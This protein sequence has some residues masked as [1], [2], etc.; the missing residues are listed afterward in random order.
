MA[1]PRIPKKARV[2]LGLLFAVFLLINSI[3][4]V[5]EAAAGLTGEG[6]FRFLSADVS[7]AARLLLFVIGIGT[8]WLLARM[9]YK[10]LI[11]GKITV[12]DSVNTAYIL[13]FYLLLTF[14]TFSFLGAIGWFWLPLLF[15][16]LLIYT[17]FTLWRLIGALFTIGVVVLTFLAMI[18]TWF[19]I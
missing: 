2:T 4:L 17:V 18:G 15:L 16:V 8:S 3:F 12:S 11:K 1:K 6:G 14:A 9:L 19:V 13:L 10:F 5:L 7:V